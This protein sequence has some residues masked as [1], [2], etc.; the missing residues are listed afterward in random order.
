MP[1]PYGLFA[2][3]GCVLSVLWLR[4]HREGLGVSENEFW[5]A[6]WTLLV[7]GVVGAKA[8]FLVL[9]WEHFAR[10]ELSLWT[11][12]RVGFVFFGGL[13]GAVI[14]GA[15]FA[16]VRR[17]S[18]VRGADYHRPRRV[19]LRRL[20]PRPP[21]APRPALRSRR[22]RADRARLPWR[23]RRDRGRDAPAGGRVPAL[24][25]ALRRAPFRPRPAP[26]R[27]SSRAIPGHLAPAGH[28]SARGPRLSALGEYGRR[29]GPRYAG[30]FTAFHL[31]RT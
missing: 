1:T 2:A 11:D 7:G 26:R 17:H 28:G 23:P 6:M 27:R 12:V 25:R 22:P 14:A 20:L 5:A 19:F 15:L 13:A 3:T 10:G 4:R 8:L 9:G 29:S 31:S 24:S 16:A 18:F 30:G 21:S